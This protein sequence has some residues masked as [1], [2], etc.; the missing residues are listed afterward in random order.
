MLKLTELNTPR[1]IYFTSQMVK[2]INLLLY[3]NEKMEQLPFDESI[4]CHRWRAMLK[5]GQTRLEQND[6]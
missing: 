6:V 4:S 3:F 2:V 1:R 5:W